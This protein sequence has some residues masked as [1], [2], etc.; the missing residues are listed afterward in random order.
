MMDWFWNLLDSSISLI[1]SSILWMSENAALIPLLVFLIIYTWYLEYRADKSNDSI[2]FEIKAIEDE[3][4]R[5]LQWDF[6]F[7]RALVHLNWKF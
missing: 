5:R 6:G 7:S 2:G 1:D 3:R 4:E